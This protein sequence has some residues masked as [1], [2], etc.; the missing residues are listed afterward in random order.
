MLSKA[1]LE[2][3]NICNLSCSFCHKT[4][5][6]R[7]LMS[8]EEFDLL[9]DRLRGKIRYLYFHLMGEP[10]LHPLLPDFIGSAHRKGF[11][12]V[13][14]TNGSL[15]GERGEA[16]VDAKPYKVS[17]SLHAPSGNSAFAD[18]NYL[19]NCIAFA[20]RAAASGTFVAL[21]LWN[22]GTEEA[23]T[24]ENV[25]ARLRMAFPEEWT[26]VRGGAGKRLATGIF[27]EYAEHF[28]WPDMSAPSIEND[29]DL[30][31]YGLRDQVGVLVDGSVVPC[32]L[33]AEGDITL[34]NLFESEL[35]EILATPRA[36]AVYDGFTARRASEELCRR[37]GYARRFSK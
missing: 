1:Y 4:K 5:R 34:G 30:F 3:T 14:T 29:A 18:P 24:N 21:R 9:T 37:C 6:E 15:L 8:A 17:V 23:A 10:T 26:D 25:I 27:L 13:I 2:I 35:D 36:R 22:L 33:D 28:E 20:N 19:D 11:L 31:C 32:C 7:R 16:L 12:P